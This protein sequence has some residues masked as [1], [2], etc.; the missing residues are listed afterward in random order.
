MPV[1]DPFLRAGTRCEGA[2]VHSSSSDMLLPSFCHFVDAK[3]V[4]IGV[5]ESVAFEG[6]SDQHAKWTYGTIRSL[7]AI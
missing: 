4:P 1:D 6:E 2:L 3:T 5:P 7:I